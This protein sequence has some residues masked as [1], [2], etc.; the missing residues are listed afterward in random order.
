MAIEFRDESERLVAE[1]AVLV[2]RAVMEAMRTAK[3][4][5]GLATVETAVLNHGQ[6]FLQKIMQEAISAHEGA[7]KKGETRS[8]APVENACD[9][10][11]TRPRR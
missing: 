2:Q 6:A 10:K 4:G 1:Q 5:H 8:P 3:H 7:Q 11:A 9:S